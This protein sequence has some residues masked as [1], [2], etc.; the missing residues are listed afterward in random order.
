MPNQI[1][2]VAFDLDG[3][4][5]NSEELYREC[6]ER[7]LTQRGHQPEDAM[8]QRMMGRTNADALKVMIDWYDLDATIQ[9]LNDETFQIMHDLMERRLEAMP[10]LL[11]LLAELEQLGLPK[12]VVTSST[13]DYLNRAL[14]KLELTDRFQFFLTAESITRGKPNPDVYLLAAERFGVEPREM[15]VLEDSVLGCRAAVDAGATDCGGTTRVSRV[16]WM[17]RCSWL[18]KGSA[19]RAYEV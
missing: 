5:I 2:A 9:Q 14:G 15:L 10:G 4:M 1:R 19:T 16:P 12:S 3:L 8:F 6:G 7:M 18:P 17:S 13:R 11:E